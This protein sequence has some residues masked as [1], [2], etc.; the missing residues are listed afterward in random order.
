ML[1]FYFIYKIRTKVQTLVLF[2]SVIFNNNK[3]KNNTET[4][5]KIFLI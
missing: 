1:T 2:F 3:F 4:E 5:L